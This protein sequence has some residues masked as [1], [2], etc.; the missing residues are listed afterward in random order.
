MAVRLGATVESDITSRTT[1][2]IARKGDPTEKM[3][4]AAKNPRIQLVSLDWLWESSSNWWTRIDEG[5]YR[6]DAKV[7]LESNGGT[8]YSVDTGEALFADPLDD[9]E[10]G[11]ESQEGTSENNLL[12]ETDIPGRSDDEHEE[13]SATPVDALNEEDWEAMNKEIEDLSESSDEGSQ[14]GNEGDEIGS[15]SETESG[16]VPDERKVSRKKRKREQ[17][18]G[19]GFDEGQSRISRQ[20]Q[21]D[22]DGDASTRAVHESRASIDG[23]VEPSDDT[24]DEEDPEDLEAAMREAL[25][26]NGDYYE[27]GSQEGV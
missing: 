15:S 13:T 27:D 20:K 24:F 2:L 19:E 1:H 6:F 5:P 26:T 25:E 12:L 10:E 14:Y 11:K 3:R 18:D 7:S 23:N 9:A 22:V 16:D 17:E 21:T 4:Q 8:G